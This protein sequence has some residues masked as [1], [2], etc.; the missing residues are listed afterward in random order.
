M[1]LRHFKNLTTPNGGVI[2]KAEIIDNRTEQMTTIDI[3]IVHLVTNRIK[4]TCSCS[5]PYPNKV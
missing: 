4:Y 5:C 1:I 3:V 2:C